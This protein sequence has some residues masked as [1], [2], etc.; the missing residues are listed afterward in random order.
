METKPER[1]ETIFRDY[2]HNLYSQ[3]QATDTQFMR[4]FLSTLDLPSI[5]I[6]NKNFTSEITMEELNKAMGRMKPNKTPGSDGFPAEWYRL[7]RDKLNPI[8]LKSLN[9]T[10]REGQIPPSWNEAIVSLIP[11]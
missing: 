8:L 6:Q 5:Q 9:F 10:I 1:I 11:K 7:F 2:F 3:D 4:N